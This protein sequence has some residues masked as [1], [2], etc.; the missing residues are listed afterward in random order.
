MLTLS[1]PDPAGQL[2]PGRRTRSSAVSL[3]G[4]AERPLE[5]QTRGG[6][7]AMQRPRVRFTLFDAMVLVAATALGLG[8]AKAIDP[9]GLAPRSGF[10][11]R[12]VFFGPSIC[13]AAS[14]ALGLLLLVRGRPRALRRRLM[15][16]P[17]LVVCFVSLLSMAIGLAGGSGFL[18]I[19][20]GTPRAWSSQPIGGYWYDAYARTSEFVIGAWVCLWLTKRWAPGRNWIDRVG[21]FVGLLWILQFLFAGLGQLL[22]HVFPQV[23]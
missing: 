5:A 2:R 21:R 18:C 22:H 4:L 6:S 19:Q 23:F 15:R 12:W 11:L 16:Q 14:W 17:G 3:P 20:T 13:L 10:F 7:R 9:E 1:S 8:L